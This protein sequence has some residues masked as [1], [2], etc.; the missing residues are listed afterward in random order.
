ME[1]KWGIYAGCINEEQL[2]EAKIEWALRLGMEVSIVEGYHPN[3]N[4]K[5]KNGLS[6]DKTTEILESYSDKIN[7]N[8]VGEVPAQQLLRHYAYKGLPEVDVA[9]M[10]DIDEFILEKDIEELDRMYNFNKN[11]K[12]TLLNSYIFLDNEYCAA[13]I[14]RN[15][16]E[17]KFNLT[18]NISYGQF[19]ERVFRYNKY[20]GY[21]RNPFLINDFYGRF[22]FDNSAYF[23]ERIVL[24][25]MYILHYKNFKMEE[26]KARHKMYEERGDKF[27]YSEEW[28][29]LEENKIKYEGEHPREIKKLLQTQK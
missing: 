10:S 1:L 19:H 21:R 15:Q 22:I 24:D 4:G 25:D 17:V 11:L 3:Y 23:N 27:N 18:R 7:Y 29:L 6:S 14:Q 28:K 8:P 13:H 2:I 16:G 9:I 12:L 5:T 26:A 20:Y